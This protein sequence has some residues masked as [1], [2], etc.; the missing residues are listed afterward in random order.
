MD[1]ERFCR[2]C[3]TEVARRQI[4]WFGQFA[5]VD[6]ELIH[7]VEAGRGEPLIL[8][9]GFLAWSYTWRRNVGPLSEHARVLALDLRGFGLSEKR[10][11]LRH[12]LSDQ[13]EV[14]RG[15]M[16]RLSIKQAVIC[17]HSMGGEIAMRFA[18]KYPDRV[19]A[20]ILVS[21]SGYVRRNEPRMIRWALGMPGVNMLLV[22]LAMM[23][24][25]F[26]M[27]NIRAVYRRPER[28]TEPEVEAYL[29][30]SRAPGMTRA[31]L[32]ILREADF[33]AFAHRLREIEHRALLIWGEEDQVV[34]L[35]HGKRLAEELR[36]SELAVLPDCGHVPPEEEPE[37][38]N[39]A[40]IGFLRSLRGMAEAAQADGG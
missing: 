27:E 18:L 39:E 8:V 6:G 4:G 21:A 13:V 12:G 10:G 25:R 32:S 1:K 33:G 14:L 29:L 35:S 9:H 2:W 11:G 15:F 7:Y 24:R 5:E 17:G 28:M 38:F 22:R 30:P 16:D 20:L 23:N 34:P 37:R 31:L 36:H 40:V 3:E 26:A 19:K